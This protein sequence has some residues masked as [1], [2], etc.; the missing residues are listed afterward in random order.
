MPKRRSD[1]NHQQGKHRKSK[2]RRSNTQFPSVDSH[3]QD[4]PYVSI[5]L[6]QAKNSG[7]PPKNT[8]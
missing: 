4:H 2:F 1:R 3:P 7:A 5:F 8:V 6:I